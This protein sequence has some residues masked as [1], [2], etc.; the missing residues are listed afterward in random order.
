MSIA[1]NTLIFTRG[2]LFRPVRLLVKRFPGISHRFLCKRFLRDFCAGDFSEISVQEI[3]QRFLC[4]R[5]LR[6]FSSRDFSEISLQEISQES[7]CPIG[8]LLVSKLL[9][10]NT[11]SCHFFLS[12][13]PVT[14]SCHFLQFCSC[15]FRLPLLVQ[16]FRQT[17]HLSASG[18]S[19]VSLCCLRSSSLRNDL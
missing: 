18:F 4:K 19:C 6:D 12:L 10:S 7:L 9:F 2:R 13:L 17:R 5:F 1:T 16:V 15:F 14:S 11:S 8:N 3:S